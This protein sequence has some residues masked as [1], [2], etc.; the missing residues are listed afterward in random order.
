LRPA[1]FAGHPGATGRALHRQ[2]L[3]QT[4]PSIPSAASAK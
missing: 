4:L 3:T 2:M 1:L